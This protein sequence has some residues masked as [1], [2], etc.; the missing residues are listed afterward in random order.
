MGELNKNDEM[1][2][3]SLFN[4]LVFSLQANEACNHAITEINSSLRDGSKLNQK[5]ERNLK[6]IRNKTVELNKTIV[7]IG[8]ALRNIMGI[9][10]ALE[11][12]RE[13]IEQMYVEALENSTIEE[14]K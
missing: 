7:T 12:V 3:K 5:A 1:I 14:R 4:A 13:E 10:N 11:G 6:Y 9:E 2:T 8:N